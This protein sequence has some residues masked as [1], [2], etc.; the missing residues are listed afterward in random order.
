MEIQLI[1][2][3]ISLIEKLLPTIEAAVARGEVTPEQQKEVRDRY[4][5]LIADVN[6]FNWPEWKVE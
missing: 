5:A 6:R 3:A 4:L 1:I 2:L